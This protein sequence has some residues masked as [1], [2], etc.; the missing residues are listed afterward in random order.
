MKK[1][2]I[3]V[4]IYEGYQETRECIE[5]LINYNDTLICKV[6]LINDKSPNIQINDYLKE[7]IFPKNFKVIDNEKNLGFV[8]TVN[9]GMKISSKNDIILLNSD[10]VVTP[11]WYKNLQKI[12][13]VDSKIATVTSPTN[14]GTI[15]SFPLYNRDNELN[16][17]QNNLNQISSEFKKNFGDSY[18]VI[19]TCVGHAVFIKR[20][21]INKIGYFN[22]MLFGKGYGEE[23]DF[24]FRISK[25]GYSNVLALNTFILHK[26]STS[27]K[28]NKKTLI[29]DHKKILKRI[30]F[31]KYLNMWYFTNYKK[32]F[33]KQ[34]CEKNIIKEI[35]KDK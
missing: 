12:A 24:S 2:D 7:E 18:T 11:N 3:I 29:E 10:T 35:F 20:E 5:S 4:P 19:P 27:F 23:V 9:K 25:H 33:V 8:K 14:N 28:D 26:G 15:S 22:E 32:N 16:V 17:N 1:I 21:V 6:Y 31:F 13:Y 34:L 30:H